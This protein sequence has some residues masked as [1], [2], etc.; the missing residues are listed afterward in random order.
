MSRTL[1]FGLRF[2]LLFAVLTTAFEASR[3]TAFERF[4]VEDLILTPT[5]HMINVLTP[6]EGVVMVDRTL[7]SAQGSRLRITRGCEGVEMFL[8]LISAIATFPA[9]A[10]RRISGLLSGSVLAYVLS[11]GRLMALHYILQYW[12]RAWES[13]HGLILP[14]GP[15]VLL[16][17][18]FLWWS[19]KEGDATHLPQDRHAT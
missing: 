12:P 2:A 4:V 5:V 1:G 13:A 19:S 6:N 8:L 14:L 16:A 9:R 10:A 18:F 15:I 7:V 3:G 11:V 17:L